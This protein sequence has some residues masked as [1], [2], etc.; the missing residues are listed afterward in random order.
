L[1]DTKFVQLQLKVANK[2]QDEARAIRLQILLKGFLQLTRCSTFAIFLKIP[3][4]EMF[5]AQF[6]H[7]FVLSEW[8]RLQDPETFAKSKI[9]GREA[10]RKVNRLYKL[11]LFRKHSHPMNT[12]HAFVDQRS[13]S[14]FVDET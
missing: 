1:D 10:L 13:N 12:G 2:L 9:F 11:V 8:K 4:T 14:Y 5:F 7:M 6:R 3:T